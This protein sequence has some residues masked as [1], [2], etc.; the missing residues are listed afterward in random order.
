M[1][2]LRILLLLMLILPAASVAEGYID[3]LVKQKNELEAVILENSKYGMH[4]KVELNAEL[5]FIEKYVF[6]DEA[7]KSIAALNAAG[8]SFLNYLE[9]TDD[10]YND[11]DLEGWLIATELLFE[12]DDLVSKKVAWGNL[13]IKIAICNKIFYWMFDYIDSHK[14]DIKP[15]VFNKIIDIQK[16]LRRHYPSN[17]SMLYIALRYYGV[18]STLNVESYSLS[19]PYSDELE[20]LESEIRS[21]LGDDARVDELMNRL[22]AEES[23][24]TI[25]SYINLY[26]NPVPWST[27][28]STD[29]FHDCWY[30]YVYL[31]AVVKKSVS[32]PN[33][34]VTKTDLYDVYKNEYQSAEKFWMP[35]NAIR[36]VEKPDIYL[37]RKIKNLKQEALID[38]IKRDRASVRLRKKTQGDRLRTSR[39]W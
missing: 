6:K 25:G 5:G 24:I 1:Y 27:S 39:L 31:M 23:R 3:E 37:K 14:G 2:I 38:R 15:D 20:M 10:V 7:N 36:L 19:I 12:I 21:D 17:T 26:E 32:M 30:Y 9:N 18:N 13:V 8:R 33:E 29:Y 11:L 35:R 16:K 4:A 22:S 34:I 28:F